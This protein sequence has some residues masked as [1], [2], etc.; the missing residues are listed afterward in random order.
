[1]KK[2]IIIVLVVILAI[3]IIFSLINWVSRPLTIQEQAQNV[4]EDV[5][6]S[7]AVLYAFNSKFEKYKGSLKGSMVKALVGEVLKN[8]ESNDKKVSIQFKGTKYSN[9]DIS[10]VQGFIN[11]SDKYNVSIE[12]GTNKQV[13]KIIID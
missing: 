12:Y 1:M 4:V 11:T 5:E 10:A 3:A 6:L 7:S 2:I 13:E 9:N 8:N